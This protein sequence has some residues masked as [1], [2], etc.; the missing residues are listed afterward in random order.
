[1]FYLKI[2]YITFAVINQYFDEIYSR[3]G[4]VRIDTAAVPVKS[5]AIRSRY[6]IFRVSLYP[7]ALVSFSHSLSSA[8]V[9]CLST[10]T[11]K[12]T[13]GGL[14]LCELVL[15]DWVKHS[16]YKQRWATKQRY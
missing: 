4:L 1:M 9:V 8:R 5:I 12:V 15:C 13:K 10:E 2:Y 3:S 7:L 14:K 11:N 16:V 6:F